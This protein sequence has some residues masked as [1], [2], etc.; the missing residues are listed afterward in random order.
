MGLGDA[1]SAAL[2]AVADL[3]VEARLRLV[4]VGAAARAP[5]VETRAGRLRARVVHVHD[6]DTIIVLFVQDGR[7][8]RRRCRLSDVDAPE[9]TG[10]RADR[11]RAIEARDFLKALLPRGPLTLHYDGFDKYGR[12]LV[13]FRV[14]GGWVA[15]QLLESGHA[16]PMGKGGRAPRAPPA[17]LAPSVP[18]P[19]PAP[20]D[21]PAPS[22]PPAPRDF[23]APSTPPAPRDSPA[24]STPLAPGASGAPGAPSTPPAPGAP[25]PRGQTLTRALT[26]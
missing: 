21:S 1:L 14:R 24:P 2:G 17:P 23:P 25:T 19:P 22:T 4:T 6:G 13:R 9:L 12:L 10:P 7:L 16:R 3:V 15:D 5:R 8:R 20:R 18:P 11:P 26:H